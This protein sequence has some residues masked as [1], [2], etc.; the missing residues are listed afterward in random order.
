[1]PVSRNEL[2]RMADKQAH[3]EQMSIGMPWIFDPRHFLWLV[4]DGTSRILLACWSRIL[5][6]DG[7]RATSRIL[8][9]RCGE[10][11]EQR[12]QVVT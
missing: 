11:G 5:L 8:H 10:A 2:G 7:L 1:M 4:G 3:H 12:A 6:I 9:E